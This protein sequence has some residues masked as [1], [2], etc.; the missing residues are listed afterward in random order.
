MTKE[1]FCSL[2]PS[3]ALGLVYDLARSKLEPLPA[4]RAPLPPKFDAKIGRKGGFCWASELTLESLEWWLEK[5]R[6]SVESG[7]PYADRDVKTVEVLERFAA[8][9]RACPT[10]AWS[11]TRGKDRVAAGS[12]SR[13][14]A[15]HVWGSRGTAALDVRPD[16]RESQLHDNFGDG[17]DP[18]DD[19][20]VLPF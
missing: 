7:G 6:E 10:Q 14:P 2:P 13:E 11:G 19:D 4:P 18:G 3:M 16:D 1:E 12:P 5:K 20:D 9:R 17:D 15:V 8:W